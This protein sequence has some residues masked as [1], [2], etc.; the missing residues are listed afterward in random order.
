MNTSSFVEIVRVTVE[1]MGK[2]IRVDIG[3]VT[4]VMKEISDNDA[5]TLDAIALAANR[6]VDEAFGEHIR[7]GKVVTPSSEV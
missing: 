1:I 7:V 4:E 6:F 3:P 5:K 2:T